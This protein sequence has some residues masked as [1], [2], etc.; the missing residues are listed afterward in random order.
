LQQAADPFRPDVT[1]ANL[2][3]LNVP[4]VVKMM[5]DSLALPVSF[6]DEEIAALAPT[7][8]ESGMEPPAQRVVENIIANAPGAGRPVYFAVTVRSDISA[9]YADRLVLEG[10]V[11]RVA[12][13]KPVALLDVDRINENLT[14]HYR[15]DWPEPLPPWPQNMSP[16]TRMVAPVALNYATIYDRL[17]LHADQQGRIAEAGTY[18]PDAVKWMLRGDRK[19]SAID[20][21]DAWLL[22]EPDNA[23]AKE[24]MSELQKPD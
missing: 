22:R 12:G 15:L 4:A 20:F 1:V 21:V 3:L 18:C 5:K 23:K 7:M 13:D 6:T 9:R 11:N 24:L 19:Q 2:A 17:T 10:L 16:L 14:K 8:T